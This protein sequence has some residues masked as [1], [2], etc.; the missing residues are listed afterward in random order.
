MQMK[1]HTSKEAFYE[2]LRN[3]AEVN[4]PLVKE[5]Q[6]RTLGTLVDYKRAADGV[7]YGIIKESHQYYVKKAG[8]KQDPDVS[9]FA[10]IGGLSNITNFQYKSLAE[11]DKQRNMMFHTISEAVSLKPNKNGSKKKVNLNEDK[12]AQE[13]DSAENQLGDLDAATSA[14]EVPVEDPEA[15]MAAGLED[16]EAGAGAE[17]AGTDA[18]VA[19]AGAEEMGAG[20]LEAGL[21]AGAEAPVD[22]E[23]GAEVAPEGGE[24]GLPVDAEV[25]P[26]GGEDELAGVEDVAGGEEGLPDDVDAAVNN[27]EDGSEITK[28]LEKAIG[29][30]TNTIRKTE[31]EPA[32]TKSY[33]NSFIASFKDKLP[34][35]DIED[36]KEMAN[37]LIKVVNPDEIEGLGDSVPQDDEAELALAAEGEM[38]AE[39]GG[40]AQYAESRGYSSAEAL[41]EC[42][43]EEVGNLVSGYANAHNDGQNDGDMENVALV[44]KLINPE[45]LDKLRDDYGHEEYAEKLE[46]IV[47]GMNESSDEDNMAKLNELFGGLGSMLKGAAGKIGGDIKQGVKNVG[48]AIGDKA[49]QVGT[50]VG[51]YATSVKHAAHSAVVPVE[52]K[53]LEAEAGKLGQQIAAL[54]SRLTK[55]G[56]AEVDLKAIM[57]AISQ[58]LGASKGAGIAG[59]GLAEGGIPADSVDVQPMLKEEDEEF[60]KDELEI[61]GE[62]SPEHEESETPEF[63]AGEEEKEEKEDN[64]FANDSQSLGAAVVKPEGAETTGV[65]ITIDPDKTVNISMNEAARK[66]LIK[67][68]AEGVNTYLAESKP[69]VVKEVK[70]VEVMSES[71]V[72]LRKYI[73][74]RLEEKAGLRKPN[75]NENKK[76]AAIKKL[77][78][79]IDKQFN[80]FES[81]VSKKKDKVE[82]GW[83]GDKVGGMANKFNQAVEGKFKKQRELKQAIEA[84]PAG[85]KSALLKAFSTELMYNTGASSFVKGVSPENALEVAQQ[86]VSDPN[87]LGKLSQ[88]GGLLVYIPAKDVK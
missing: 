62:E 50:A 71:E 82:E 15:E 8:T 79:T 33:I 2:R 55:A 85:A 88:R 70:P 86:V 84:D 12:A 67:S 44:L 41:M 46:P 37:R 57:K 11:A 76:S 1:N 77:D 4:K 81:V 40:F 21:E 13:I 61:G 18:E 16:M 32:Q 9:D 29:K 52:V 78:V 30:L 17:V 35:I 72:K 56:K 20:E 45:I 23:A 75:L 5:S 64:F 51:D 28:E 60:E 24:E 83:L 14:A 66:K 6:N 48:T 53:K 31:L 27:V 74:N 42:G 25:A 68:I 22:A 38:C 65:D 3:L 10:Y 34:D 54:N 80:L 36:R 7:A 39:C 87:G 69:K 63:E 47:T 19:G 73:R 49:Q 26:E 59:L 43:E 58:Q